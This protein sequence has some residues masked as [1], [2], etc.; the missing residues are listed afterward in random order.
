MR[1]PC[2]TRHNI[3]VVV[4]VLASASPIGESVVGFI[5]VPLFATFRESYRDLGDVGASIHCFNGLRALSSA[6]QQTKL[7]NWI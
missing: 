2:N 3:V 6:L 5:H 1:I 7:A 4:L